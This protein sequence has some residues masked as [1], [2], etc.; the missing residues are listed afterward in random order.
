MGRLI[1]SPQ[2]LWGRRHI[3]R[4]VNTYKWDQLYEN[5]R[6]NSWN[7]DNACRDISTCLC[8]YHMTLYLV[9]LLVLLMTCQKYNTKIE[10][11]YDPLQSPSFPT[12]YDKCWCSVTW[13]IACSG[14]DVS[15]ADCWTLIHVFSEAINCI[16]IFLSTLTEHDT[17]F[18]R[19]TLRPHL[20]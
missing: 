8:Q 19:R 13:S 2:L 15:F 1:I 4:I 20:K 17:D 3:M 16:N 9:V 18:L 7:V 14:L 10:M 11:R 5:D 6:T 12:C